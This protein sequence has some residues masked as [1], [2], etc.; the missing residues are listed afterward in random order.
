LYNAEHDNY[1]DKEKLAL[2]IFEDFEKQ[3]S[4]QSYT[5]LLFADLTKVEQANEIK[6]K[7]R[8][9]AGPVSNI[10]ASIKK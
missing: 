2:N 8:V 5:T 4:W 3:E 10:N 6:E 9:D 1:S 7:K